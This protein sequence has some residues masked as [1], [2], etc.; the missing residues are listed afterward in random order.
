MAHE[1]TVGI[2]FWDIVIFEMAQ[3]FNFT[4]LNKINKFG[5]LERKAFTDKHTQRLYSQRLNM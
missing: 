5:Y 2:L 3:S 4:N 1:Y